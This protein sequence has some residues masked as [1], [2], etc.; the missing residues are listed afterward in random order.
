M[1]F[2]LNN[3][4]ASYFNKLKNMRE[5]E[6]V[7]SKTLPQRLDNIIKSFEII[8]NQSISA[9]LEEVSLDKL[10]PSEPFLE[11]D[12]LALVFKKIIEENYNTPIIAAKYVDAIRILDGHHR[13]YLCNK[14][15]RAY[16]MVYVLKLLK[17]REDTRI[18]YPSLEEMP[19]KDVAKIDDPYIHGWSNI[20]T[21][22]KYYE[23]IHK[24][25]FRMEEKYLPL[26]LL[27]PTQPI[28]DK[29]R[30]NSI[31][32]VIVPITCI[33]YE[34]KYYIIDG[35]V[36]VM[37][38]KRDGYLSIHSIVLLPTKKIEFGI[39]KTSEKMGLRGID[40]IKI[41]EE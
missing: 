21:L 25:F 17:S 24:T 4:K 2:T 7:D 35:H 16:I 14:L 29:R 10:H 18:S 31:G 33:S 41:I 37:A 12:K 19:I 30:L 36:R 3:F 26:N 1:A 22:L 39:V 5:I 23:E 40:D 11:K 13:S 38:A 28:V 34:D 32:K 9:D 8:Y 27:V 6:L 20:L 15:G